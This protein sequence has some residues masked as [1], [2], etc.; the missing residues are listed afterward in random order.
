MKS[1]RPPASEPSK[2]AKTKSKRGRRPKAR[3]IPK[4]LESDDLEEIAQ[5]R[6]LMIL[7][8]LSGEK[9]VTEAIKEAEI[10]R[11]F[12]YLL[13]RRAVEAMLEALMPSSPGRKAEPS[14]QIRSLEEKI[15]Q[16]EKEKRRMERLLLLTRKVLRPGPLKTTRGRPK[17]KRSNSSPTTESS[18]TSSTSIPTKA[19]ETTD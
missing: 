18:D 2:P 6:V 14:S 4:W 16:L 10:T 5:R 17:K 12:Y 1:K 9:P 7:S 3:P 15:Q 13:E 8:V 19:G 11:P